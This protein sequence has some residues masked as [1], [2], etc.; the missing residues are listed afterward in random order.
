MIFRRRQTWGTN[1]ASIFSGRMPPREGR[2]A[3]MQRKGVA[4]RKEWPILFKKSQSANGLWARGTRCGPAL[5]GISI[6]DFIPLR[7][8]KKGAKGCAGRGEGGG[9]RPAA[10]EHPI[11]VQ[12]DGAVGGKHDVNL[13]PRGT[14]FLGL[15][16]RRDRVLGSRGA[17]STVSNHAG[18]DGQHP[19]DGCLL[20]YRFGDHSQSGYRA[21]CAKCCRCREAER[22]G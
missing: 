15:A 19:G 11:V 1:Y 6:H 16:N 13:D 22:Q 5:R 17:G 14:E 21:R 3:G 10:L 2:R 7:R 8:I 9:S 12:E 18:H 4:H 20:R